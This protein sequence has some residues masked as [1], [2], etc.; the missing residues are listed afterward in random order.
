[1]RTRRLAHTQACAHD[2]YVHTT[3]MLTRVH[4]HTACRRSASSDM[5]KQACAQTGM[6]TTQAC[7][8]DNHAHARA[9]TDTHTQACAQHRHVHM[10]TMLTSVHTHTHVVRRRSASSGGGARSTGDSLPEMEVGGAP[11]GDAAC[12]HG[13]GV[14]RGTCASQ[15]SRLCGMRCSVPMLRAHRSVCACTRGVDN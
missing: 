9:H 5:H 3:R 13:R 7:A 11:S 6:R 2:T 14:C 12:V 10:T 8:H 4:T 15:S 1:M